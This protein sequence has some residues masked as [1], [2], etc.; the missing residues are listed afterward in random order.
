VTFALGQNT[1]NP[2][3]PVTEI[4][5]ALP[6]ASDVTIDIYNVRGQ[7]LKRLIAEERPAGW[8]SI[9]VDAN[10]MASGV[11]FYRMQAGDFTETRKMSILK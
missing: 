2:F 6:E 7:R 4:A 3:N 11:Y 5:F 1:P 10:D 9:R 8:H